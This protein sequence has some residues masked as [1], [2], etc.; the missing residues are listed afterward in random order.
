MAF[1]RPQKVKKKSKKLSQLSHV[2][3]L[4]K[5]TWYEKNIPKYSYQ[6]E[7]QKAI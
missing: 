7:Y 3:G 6:E 4:Y 1:S 2:H 5:Y